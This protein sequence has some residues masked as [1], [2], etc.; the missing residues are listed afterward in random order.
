MANQHSHNTLDVLFIPGESGLQLQ[1]GKG[2]KDRQY[3][4]KEFSVK[5]AY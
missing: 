4:R 1:N 3:I 5:R 2:M